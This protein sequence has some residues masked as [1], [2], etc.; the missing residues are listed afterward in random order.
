MGRGHESDVVRCG[1]LTGLA[2]SYLPLTE[3]GHP[4]GAIFRSVVDVMKEKPPSLPL[5]FLE[6]PFHYKWF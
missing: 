4:D 2:A 3:E 5:E 6:V 1:D